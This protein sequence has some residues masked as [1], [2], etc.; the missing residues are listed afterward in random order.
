MLCSNPYIA[1]IL[2]RAMVMARTSERGHTLLR[3]VVPAWS[4]G[5]AQRHV[6]RHLL[7]HVGESLHG[8]RQF[9]AT[10]GS[11]PQV[12]G[13]RVH[14]TTVAGTL[15][16]CER[17]HEREQVNLRQNLKAKLNLDPPTP[18]GCQ[19]VH[20]HNYRRMMHYLLARWEPSM[21]AHSGPSSRRPLRPHSGHACSPPP[22]PAP[23]RH[24]LFRPGN[25]SQ[26]GR[27]NS[28]CCR[29]TQ[30]Y[31]RFRNTASCMAPCN[32]LLRQPHSQ[33]RCA[34]SLPVWTTVRTTVRT[35]TVLPPNSCIAGLATY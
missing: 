31:P 32:A 23:R 34:W 2:L 17:E 1:L 19:T 12:L 10:P 6:R 26:T 11:A 30:Q 13:A 35:A 25:G 3:G 33:K 27:T 28:V 9:E 4:H 5:A 29:L 22:A 20:A 21:P 15:P 7:R 8:L 14:C 24:A 18:Q 16:L